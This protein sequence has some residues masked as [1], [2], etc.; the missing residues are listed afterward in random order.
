MVR[1]EPWVTRR[2]F[3][4]LQAQHSGVRNLTHFFRTVHASL[5]RAEFVRDRVKFSHLGAT[6][7]AAGRGCSSRRCSRRGCRRRSSEGLVSDGEPG[8][9]GS[10]GHQDGLAGVGLLGFRRLQ[11]AGV[12]ARLVFGR[13]SSGA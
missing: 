1:L 2:A 4:Q 13:R 5:V 12:A 11:V 7:G 9:A 8:R 6:C 10:A 3:R